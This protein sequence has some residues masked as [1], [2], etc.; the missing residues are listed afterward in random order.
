MHYKTNNAFAKSNFVEK[1]NFYGENGI[2]FF[3]IIDFEMERPIALRLSEINNL[4]I[5]YDIN[6]INNYGGMPHNMVSREEIEII[7]NPAAYD[8]Y[9]N[10]F[11]NVVKHEMAG[12]SYLLNL[13]LKTPIK[14]NLSLEEIFYR[15][16][17]KYRLYFK[18][19][20][21]EFVLFSP[22]TFIH[23]SGEKIFTYPI[24]GTINERIPDAGNILLNDGKERAEH[25][26]AVDLLRNDLNTVSDSVKV[27]KFCF[28]DR[29][30]TGSGAILQMTSEI[31]GRIKNG[32]QNRFGDILANMLPA[33]SVS[34][35]PK[36]KT[37]EIIKETEPCK[38]GYYCGVFGIYDGKSFDS[39]V[40]IRYIEKDGPD[41]FYRSGGGITV[42]SNPEKEYN[43]IIEKIYIPVH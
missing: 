14:I 5:R 13:T 29:V 34:G 23:I 11:D 7:K 38:R 41:Y 3:F 28:L 25:L 15:S 32:M 2:G 43:E 40:M 9:K 20:T 22:E 35:A 12:D 16:I 26:T 33:G 37:I 42:Y 36:D 30:D 21:H 17:A 31:E 4:T 39:A 8:L 19:K 27:N 10:A 18:D 1:L 24:K 6:G